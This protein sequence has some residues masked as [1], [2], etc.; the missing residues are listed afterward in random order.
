MP[1]A[2]V[3][4]EGTLRSRLRGDPLAIWGHHPSPVLRSTRSL[5]F[6]RFQR[7]QSPETD[8]GSFDSPVWAPH[9]AG[10]VGHPSP[11]RCRDR[12]S[13]F[14]PPSWRRSGGHPPGAGWSATAPGWGPGRT[15]TPAASGVGDGV[16]PHHLPPGGPPAP[17]PHDGPLT[18][19]HRSG[20]G[21]R[22]PPPPDRHRPRM[23]AGAGSTSSAPSR[24]KRSRCSTTIVWVTQPGQEPPTSPLQRRADL[25]LDPPDGEPLLSRYVAIRAICRSRSGR[26]SAADPRAE[27][28]VMLAG[29]C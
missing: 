18:A 13:G 26:R 8:G 23:T 27:R 4:L 12:R 3:P 19:E 25:G 10:F 20:S 5:A 9:E 17:G 2:K 7:R 16:P 15:R 28:A 21:S 11:G 29:G 14:G 24:A 1:L 6:A 22:S